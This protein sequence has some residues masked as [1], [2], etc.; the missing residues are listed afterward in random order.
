[1]IFGLPAGREL[2]AAVAAFENG[3]V[4]AVF[5]D[6]VTIASAALGVGAALTVTLEA[7]GRGSAGAAGGIA[8]AEAAGSSV[9]TACAGS[10]GGTALGLGEGKALGGVEAGAPAIGIAAF[11]AGV[12]AW[13]SQ[14]PATSTSTHAPEI[15]SAVTPTR[16]R[17][18][19]ESA[20]LR[21]A[22]TT[23]GGVTLF[24]RTDSTSG[25]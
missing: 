5:A 2:L 13:R 6:A 18:G 8:A 11:A 7:D 10:R 17:G 23:G 24:G 12:R 14:P 3:P 22:S 15:T 25:T 4:E 20:S 16:R 19:T 21:P 9:A 1:M